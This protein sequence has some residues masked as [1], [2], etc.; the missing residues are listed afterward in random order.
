MQVNIPY[1]DGMATK[2]QP[3]KN[4]F[5]LNVVAGGLE[6]P[7]TLLLKRSRF[8]VDMENNL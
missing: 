2:I 8:F 5:H 3:L 7:S 1:M 6:D 4:L